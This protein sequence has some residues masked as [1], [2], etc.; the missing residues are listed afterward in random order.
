MKNFKFIVNYK[1]LILILNLKIVNLPIQKSNIFNHPNQ[2]II[3]STF[4]P[5]IIFNMKL[6]VLFS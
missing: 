2:C 1:Y 5:I 4:N 6:K 3:C